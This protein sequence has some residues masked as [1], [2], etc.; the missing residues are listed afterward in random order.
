MSLKKVAFLVGGLLCH[1][2]RG[3]E[4]HYGELAAVLK[5][6]MEALGSIITQ[7]SIEKKEIFP[8]ENTRPFEI[9]GNLAYAHEHGKRYTS[10]DAIA[11][12]GIDFSYN[13]FI[14]KRI[15]TAGVFTGIIKDFMDYHGHSLKKGDLRMWFGGY[16][17]TF[18]LWG[19]DISSVSVIG[20]GQSKAHGEALTLHGGHFDHFTHHHRTLYSKVEVYYPWQWNDLKIGPAFALHTNNMKQKG[21]K[22]WEQASLRMNLVD[23]AVGVK[24][25][26]D[27]QKLYAYVF[28][29]CERNFCQNFTGGEI[30]IDHVE[31]KLTTSKLDR[32]KFLITTGI[33]FRCSESCFWNF[34]FS[35]RYGSRSQSSTL[36]AALNKVF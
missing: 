35:G 1:V 36:C 31:E 32:T 7:H 10:D 24:C 22:E 3:A 27:H 5:D 23:G 28:L 17:S 29:G 9:C 4:S 18:R 34:N 26:K 30:T 19:L 12:L 16:Y 6:N 2:V 13:N 11:F 25:E 14:F 33:H 8:R 15:C 21:A 20:F